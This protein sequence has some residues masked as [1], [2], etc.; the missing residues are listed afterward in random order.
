LK[1]ALENTKK[2]NKVLISEYITNPLLLSILERKKFHVRIYFMVSLIHGHFKTHVFDFYEIFTADRPYKKADWFNKDI[3]DTHARD[4]DD[5]LIF[6]MDNK[7]SKLRNDFKDKYIPKMKDCL[8]IISKFIKGKIGCYPQ[9][10][11]AFEIFGCDFLIK[12]DGNIV[13]ME[14]NDKVGYKCQTTKNT[15]RLSQLFF[16]EV[17]KSVLEPIKLL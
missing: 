4:N 16:N 9:A 13:L 15:I 8:G 10:E 5:E 2:Y 1:N 17:I 12:D 11:N 14:I 6:P 7:D 3:H